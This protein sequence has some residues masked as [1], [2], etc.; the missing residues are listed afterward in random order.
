M[1]KESNLSIAKLASLEALLCIAKYRLRPRCIAASWGHIFASDSLRTASGHSEGNAD[2]QRALPRRM[3]VQTIR[4]RWVLWLS[5][6]TKSVLSI[7][8]KWMWLCDNIA[9]YNISNTILSYS[10]L[11]AANLRGCVA[12]KKLLVTRRTRNLQ[13][14][15]ATRVECWGLRNWRNVIFCD[16]FRVILYW[17]NDR[18]IVWREELKRYAPACLQPVRRRAREELCA[19]WPPCRSPRNNEQKHVYRH[20][21]AAHVAICWSHISA[22]K[23]V[24]CLTAR[25]CPVPHCQTQHR[26]AGKATLQAQD[27]ASAK[28]RHERH[29]NS[30][31]SGYG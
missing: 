8:C 24:V 3:S 13:Q 17:Y 28:S 4:N 27:V 14:R 15:W 31:G 6:M 16:E 11:H 1:G 2:W 19:A 25:Q 30:V 7:D 29:W 10:R 20:L 22:A 5:L 26:L 18:P 9:C 23:S 21:A 12:K